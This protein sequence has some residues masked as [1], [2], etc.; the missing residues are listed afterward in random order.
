[1]NKKHAKEEIVL[2]R[3]GVL[4]ATTI[5]YN[6]CKDVGHKKYSYTVKMYCQNKLD[7]NGWLI[8]NKIINKAMKEAMSLITSCEGM[9]I[10]FADVLEDVILEHGVILDKLYVYVEPIPDDPAL[11]K[12]FA[13]FELCRI[14]NENSIL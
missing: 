8:D 2:H 1:M 12:D 5:A 14:Y 11:A 3:F 9:C 7:H 10:H 4:E 6:Q 13:A